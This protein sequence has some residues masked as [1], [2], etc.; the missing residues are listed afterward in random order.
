M[1][2]S[3]EDAH[4]HPPRDS[5]LFSQEV[6]HPSTSARVPEKVG[7]GVFSTGVLVLQA[8]HEFILDFMQGVVQPRQVAARVVVPPSVVPAFLQALRDNLNMYQ[9]QFGPPPTLRPPP[10]GTPLPST[11]EIYA[12]FKLPDDLL[13]GAYANAAMIVHTQGEFCL[14]FIT[15]FYPRSAVSC[16]VYLAA[17]QAPVLLNTLTQAWQK[18][19]QRLSAPP[20]APP[21]PPARPS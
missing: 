18:Y 13:S 11:E 5:G 16:R 20:G 17:A 12:Q 7:R 21:E 15:T 2:G 6:Q 4:Q 10:P 1:S 14:D 9:T 19:Q 8:A 3:P